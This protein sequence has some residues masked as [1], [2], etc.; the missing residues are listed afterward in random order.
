MALIVLTTTSA[1][2][3]F[4]MLAHHYSLIISIDEQNDKV[5][6]L[7]LTITMAKICFQHFSHYI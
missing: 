6:T 3:S 5:L 4:I 1:I 2:L 7:T